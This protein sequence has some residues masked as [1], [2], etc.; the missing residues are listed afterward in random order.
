MHK[1]NNTYSGLSNLLLPLWNKIKH[2]KM[3]ASAS[4]MRLDIKK[5]ISK[6][7]FISDWKCQSAE[8]WEKVP[9]PNHP[10]AAQRKDSTVPKWGLF[11]LEVEG[12][13]SPPSSGKL[14]L[15]TPTLWLWGT[16]R[17]TPFSLLGAGSWTN[18]WSSLGLRVRP[19][20]HFIWIFKKQSLCYKLGF[21]TQ[22]VSGNH[23]SWK[24]MGPTKKRAER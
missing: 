18:T 10:A 15:P 17:R 23:A 12:P 5:K 14:I 2:I 7:M 21:E 16:D 11:A 24:G 22:Y 1:I 8:L 9:W 6:G 3:A 19:K 13:H 20:I 4:W